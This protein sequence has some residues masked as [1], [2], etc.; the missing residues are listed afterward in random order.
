MALD[1]I[2]SDGWCVLEWHEESV[3]VISLDR[4]L[5]PY[6]SSLSG[7]LVFPTCLSS[8]FPIA[9][10]PRT[11]HGA[12]GIIVPTRTIPQVDKLNW[13]KGSHDV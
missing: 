12:S 5:I 8:S 3:N 1:S 13:C 9:Y 11:G 6:V 4:V 2:C 7:V 10:C